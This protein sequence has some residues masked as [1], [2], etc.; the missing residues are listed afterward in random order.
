MSRVAPE[1]ADIS[2]AIL[3]APGWARV[4]ITMPDP[5]MRERGADELARAIAATLTNGSGEDHR[6][7][8]PLGI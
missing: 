4:A 8:L 5:H 2:A 3:S 1:A 6:D 7:Q